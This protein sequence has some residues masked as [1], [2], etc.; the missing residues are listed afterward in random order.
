MMETAQLFIVALAVLILS[1]HAARDKFV[2]HLQSFDDRAQVSY[3]FGKGLV[4]SKDAQG[5][6]GAVSR[7]IGL[8]YDPIDEYFLYGTDNFGQG[9]IRKYIAVDGTTKDLS[10]YDMTQYQAPYEFMKVDTVFAGNKQ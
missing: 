6:D 4:D 3:V 7:P 5:V 8:I 2:P 9:L 1:V 10:S